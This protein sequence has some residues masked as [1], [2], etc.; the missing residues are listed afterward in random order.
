MHHHT[1]RA[2]RTYVNYK[3]APGFF[4]LVVLVGTAIGAALVFG[5]SAIF[6]FLFGGGIQ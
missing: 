5:L 1:E 6:H 3:L 2:I 4:G